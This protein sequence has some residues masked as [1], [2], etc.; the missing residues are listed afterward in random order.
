MN[1]FIV[2]IAGGTG[3]GKTTVVARL[4]EQLDSDVVVIE[5]DS[6]YSP[7]RDLSFEQRKQVNYDHPDSLETALLIEH[8]QQLRGTSTVEIPIYDFSS[9]ERRQETRRVGPKAVIIVDGILVLADKAL[10]D[11]LDLSVFVSTSDDIRLIRRLQRDRV[12]RGRTTDSVIQQYLLT[13]K[14]MHERFV[15]PSQCHADLI[16]QGDREIVP[17]VEVLQARLQAMLPR[18]ALSSGADR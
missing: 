3:S 6:Y 7:N 2:G 13:I 1:P 8:L 17:V 14:P 10:R 11:C 4:V 9:H 18:N 5:H 12:E 16:V 15:Q